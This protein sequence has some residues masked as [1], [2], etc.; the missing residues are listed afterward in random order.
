MWRVIPAL[1]ILLM[2]SQALAAIS[3]TILESPTEITDQPFSITFRVEG[4]SPAINYFRADLFQV[5]GN[6]Y[7]GETNNGSA[8]YG[9]GSGVEYFPLELTSKDQHI[10]TLSARLGEPSTARYPGPGSYSLRVRRYTASGSQGGETPQVVPVKISYI[11]PPTPTPTP[12]PTATPA[13]S[14]S[15]SPTP[16]ATPT[17]TP[18]PIP[19]PTNTPKPKVSLPTEDEVAT[20]QGLTTIELSPSPSLSPSTA[21][22]PVEEKS[23]LRTLLTLGIGLLVISA[24]LYLYSIIN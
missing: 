16:T 12:T 8:W 21:P 20:I 18:T 9:G 17:P 23:P 24:G 7:F 6:D 4:V 22:I 1:L 19:T 10:A 3:V 15:P 14:P 5:D 13:P 11:R 2:P